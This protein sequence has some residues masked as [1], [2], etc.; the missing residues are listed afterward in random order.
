MSPHFSVKSH[1]HR[2]WRRKFWCL[3]DSVTTRSVSSSK[4]L[5]LTGIRGCYSLFSLYLPGDSRENSRKCWSIGYCMLTPQTLSSRTLN[6]SQKSLHFTL[7]S[8]SHHH[9]DLSKKIMGHSVPDVSWWWHQIPNINSAKGDVTVRAWV[10]KSRLYVS[11]CTLTSC[12][13]C[14]HQKNYLVQMLM[15]Q[16]SLC[17]ISAMKYVVAA[18]W[19]L[20]QLL[21]SASWSVGWLTGF[22]C[23]FHMWASQ[24]IVNR[25]LSE[26]A[27]HYQAPNKSHDSP[28]D[29]S[30]SLFPLKKKSY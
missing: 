18:W 28:W 23:W 13:N 7:L 26:G 21:Q 25:T 27:N 24:L 15:T 9:F 2:E 5:R 16:S 1:G 22:I 19:W 29:P 4:E 11:D 8:V 6:T 12:F 30:R 10:L 3:S 17:I 20:Q 14:L